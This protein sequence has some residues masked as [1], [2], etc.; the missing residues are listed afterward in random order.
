MMNLTDQKN[1]FYS[2]LDKTW[3]ADRALIEGWILCLCVVAVTVVAMPLTALARETEGPPKPK[4]VELTTTDGVKLNVTYYE[5]TEGE[6][7]VPVVVIHDWKSKEDGA[8]YKTLAE[9]LQSRGYAVILPDLRG[10]GDSTTQKASGR[11]LKLDPSKVRPESVLAG[12][13][14][15]VRLFLLKENN[16]KRLNL[17]A[18]TLIGVGQGAV[19]AAWYAIYDWDDFARYPRN[20][21]GK[22]RLIRLRRGGE[23]DVKAL[24]LISPANKIGKQL[25]IDALAR[26]TEVGS[27]EVSTMILVGQKQVEGKSNKPKETKESKTA[28]YI[29]ERLKRNGHEVDSEDVSKC[30]LFLKA[31]NTELNGEKLVNETNLDLKARE[32][33]RAFLNLRLRDRSVPWSERTAHSN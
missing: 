15:A 10:H 1:R 33:V 17:A 2:P 27:G 24:V 5:G 30:S 11:T 26:H 16:A 4:T 9:Y 23:K 18:T 14:E 6:N 19:L 22:Q 12:D 32:T 20:D 25:K 8:T 21:P 13:L 28:K 29:Y 31:I 3:Q 7:T